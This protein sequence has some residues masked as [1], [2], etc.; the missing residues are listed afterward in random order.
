[1]AMATVYTVSI[2]MVTVFRYPEPKEEQ[3]LK[4]VCHSRRLPQKYSILG[5]HDF[6]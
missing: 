2:V 4:L 3:L 5:S 1:M 6:L